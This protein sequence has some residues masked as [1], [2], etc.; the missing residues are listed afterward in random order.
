[1]VTTTEK[2]PGYRIVKVIGL[3]SGSSAKA[4]HIGRDIMASLRNIAGG[5]VKEYTE[6]MAESRDT[7]LKRMMEKAEKMGANAI[8]GVRL[9][10][11]MIASGVAEIV[12]Y[13]T[14]VK[15]EPET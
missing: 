7:A 10:T 6:L 15:V 5:E 8:I 11:S 9:S 13:G 4:K 3:V 14:A 12:F 1:M 2:I